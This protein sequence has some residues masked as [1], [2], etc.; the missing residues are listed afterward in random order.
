MDNNWNEI[1]EEVILD[2]QQ[3]SSS[4]STLHLKLANSYL[5]KYNF[6]T[7]LGIILGP[8]SAA[9]ASVNNQ[10]CSYEYKFLH[11][12]MIVLSM[13]SG[14]IMSIIKFGK[15]DEKCNKNRVAA[16]NYI[17]IDHNIK[18]QL[19]LKKEDRMDSNTY[20]EWLQ[21]KFD[22]T[23]SNSPLLPENKGDIQINKKAEDIIVDLDKMLQYEFKRLQKMN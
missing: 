22:N 3:K 7:I 18:Q 23:F 10:H 20:L 6:L 15:Y 5:F 2:I 16:T 12:C 9:I 1:I 4:N 19:M 11:T 8:M 13:S 14:I 17:T 21:Q